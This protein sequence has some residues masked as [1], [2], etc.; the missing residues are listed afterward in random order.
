MACVMPTATQP[1]NVFSPLIVGQYLLYG[2]DCP[3]LMVMSGAISGVL[4]ISILAL[5]C[6]TRCHPICSMLPKS[7]ARAVM[8][9]ALKSSS[10][11]TGA[12]AANSPVVL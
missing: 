2:A 9:L 11:L 4:L 6:F 12:G 7:L 5:R 8:S 3:R 10:S 1:T